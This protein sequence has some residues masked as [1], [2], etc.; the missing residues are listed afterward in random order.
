MIEMSFAMHSIVDTFVTLKSIDQFGYHFHPTESSVQRQI[1]KWP[2][3]APLLSPAAWVDPRKG[4]IEYKSEKWEFAFHGQGISFFNCE[5]NQEV[6]VEYT[7]TGELGITKWTVQVY[8]ES[9][10]TTWPL[11]QSLMEQHDHLFDELVRLGYL[12]EI[13]PRLPFDDQTF[14]L[15]SFP[16]VE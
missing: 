11:L 10:K 16:S 8:L 7:A 4:I 9:I 6:S 14:V 1:S 3:D 13:P 15:T 5:T 2:E 12:R